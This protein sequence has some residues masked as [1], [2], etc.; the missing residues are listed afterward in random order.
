MLAVTKQLM[1]EV[2]RVVVLA[3]PSWLSWS[4]ALMQACCQPHFNELT[5]GERGS[6]P[7]MVFVGDSL[8]ND[9]VQGA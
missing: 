4:A 8:D 3:E 9:A 7:R 5:R 2:D 1:T 6:R